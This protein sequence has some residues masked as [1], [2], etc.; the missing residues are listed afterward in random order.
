MNNSFDTA[1][2]MLFFIRDDT[3]AQVFEAVRQA[4]PKRLYLFQTVQDLTVRMIWKKCSVA[5]K[6]VKI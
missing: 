6:S 3:F 2:V 5:E 4:K 1:V